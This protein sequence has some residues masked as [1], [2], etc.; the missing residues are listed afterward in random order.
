MRTT[1]PSSM[2]SLSVILQ[3]VELLGPP[4]DGALA[5][6]SDQRRQLVGQAS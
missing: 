1:S 2:F 4:V 5:V 3:V 6:Q